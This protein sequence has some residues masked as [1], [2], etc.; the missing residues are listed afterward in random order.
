M[1]LLLACENTPKNTVTQPATPEPAKPETQ[2]DL[3]NNP[4]PP[5]YEFAFRLDEPDA[6]F[7]MPGKLT[8]ISG[9]SL[10]SDGQFLLANNDEEGKIFY[11]S[12]ENGK[13]VD[14]IKF[15]S[16][17]D[18]EGIE[19]VGEEI[20]VVKSNGTIVRVK[21]SDKKKDR[22][23]SYKTS[24]N[25][26]ND[27][28]GLAFDPNT[29]YLLLACK[30][31][32]GK[33]EEFKRKRAVY[34]FDLAGNELLEKPVFLIGRDEIQKWAGKGSASLTQK[35]AEFFEPS[36]ADDAFAP[37]G[38]AIHPMTREIY[39]LSSVGK[40]LVVLNGNGEILHI[41][42]LDPKLHRQPE[43]ICFDRDGTLFIANEGKDG[44]GKIFRFAIH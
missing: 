4:P 17:G 15:E 27:V 26:D 11:L 19:M 31:K 24:L 7:T 35:L 34:A 13:V 10:T 29:G 41:E 43:G 5:P 25:S 28:E 8:E 33:G 12:K 18:Y 44:S 20:Y 22:A 38:I 9:L 14:E 39:I 2:T 42:P 30:G 40:I 32:A 37:S 21:N 16:S 36:L 6:T 23:K 3:E 1:L